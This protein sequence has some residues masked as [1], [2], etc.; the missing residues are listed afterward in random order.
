MTQACVWC[1][2][3][4][5]HLHLSLFLPYKTCPTLCQRLKQPKKMAVPLTSVLGGSLRKGTA[6]F[7]RLCHCCSS[8]KA[9]EDFGRWKSTFFRQSTWA[10]C[11]KKGCPET[12]LCHGYCLTKTLNFA[13]KYGMIFTSIEV[14]KIAFFILSV[15][16]KY[17]QMTPQ[18][19]LK[20]TEHPPI[21]FKSEGALSRFQKQT[22]KQTKVRTQNISYLYFS[23]FLIH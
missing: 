22:N 21:L 5:L 16:R 14:I 10:L 4:Q 1:L 23:Q 19:G 17:R 7:R 3:S 20:S 9:R 15:T 12:R 6:S 2:A 8:R 13:G 18:F 11:Q